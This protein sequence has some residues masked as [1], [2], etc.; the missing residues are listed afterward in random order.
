MTA[1]ELFG[2]TLRQQRERRNLTLTVIADST[3]ISSY[4]LA[5][6]ERGDVSRWPGGI[7]RRAF[8]RAYASAVGLPPEPTLCEFVSLFPE[9]GQDPPD[10][11]DD[12]PRRLRLVLVEEPRWKAPALR[13]AAAFVDGGVVVLVA[14]VMTTFSGIGFWTAAGLAGLAYHAA[15]AVVLGR[16]A[17]AWLVTSTAAAQ[18]PDAIRDQFAHL[19]QG[20]GPGLLDSAK[21]SQEHPAAT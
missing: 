19:R 8:V 11:M 4:L 2:S 16:S 7:Y 9:P 20:W 3:K 5:S 21:S 18:R 12:D 13:S 1:R 17:G 15:G 10:L 6:L 14:G